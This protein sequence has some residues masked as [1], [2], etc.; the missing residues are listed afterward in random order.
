MTVRTLAVS[1]ISLGFLAACDSDSASLPQSSVLLPEQVQAIAWNIEE[2]YPSLSN[3]KRQE[4]LTLAVRSIDEMIYVEGGEFEM[5]D[6]GW[7]CDFDPAQKCDWPCGEE[8]ENL[9]PI[10]SGRDNPLHPVKLDSYYMASKKTTLK[11]FDLFRESHGLGIFDE[12]LH[13]REDLKTYYLPKNPAP[14][15]DWQQAKDY[16]NW[17]GELSGYPVDL[18]TE[19]QWEFAARDRG[20]RILYPTSDGTLKIGKNFPDRNARPGHSATPT[21]VDSYPPNPLGIYM[22]AGSATEWVN[23]WYSE[24]YYSESPALNPPGPEKGT[25]KVARGFPAGDSP[26]ASA[27]TVM[28]KKRPSEGKGF[29]PTRSF[30]CSLQSSEK[31]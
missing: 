21:P 1:L 22:A 30:R 31:L 16:C 18:P 7:I 28:R 19:A 11:D 27:Y 23:D 9:C 29:Y 25:E 6:F 4:I 3:S 20:K 15:K 10:T 17:I 14:T 2:K 12:A 13:K 5:G 8:P 24:N 26:W